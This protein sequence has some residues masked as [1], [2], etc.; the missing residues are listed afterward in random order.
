MAVERQPNSD[1]TNYDR[2]QFMNGV[3]VTTLSA[4]LTI[5]GGVNLINDIIKL[6]NKPNEDEKQVKDHVKT[7]A[8]EGSSKEPRKPVSGDLIY[9]ALLTGF[10]LKG[11]EFGRK[12]MS[13][14]K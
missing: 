5:S 1:Y 12:L 10:G 6:A 9:D 14:H 13:R 3:A 2:R 7:P 8:I 4:A 11:V